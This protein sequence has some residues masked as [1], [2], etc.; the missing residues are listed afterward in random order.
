[1]SSPMFFITTWD[2]ADVISGLTSI[3]AKLHQVK[4]LNSETIEKHR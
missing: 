3:N 4:G 2:F 1:M